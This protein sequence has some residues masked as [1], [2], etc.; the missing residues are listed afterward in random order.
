MLLFALCSEPYD[1]SRG[2]TKPCLPV[3][4]PYIADHWVVHTS[5]VEFGIQ[6]LGPR[7]HRD[8]HRPVSTIV[9]PVTAWCLEPF[10]HSGNIRRMIEKYLCSEMVRVFF[11][12]EGSTSNYLKHVEEFPS[13]LR[14]N[15]SD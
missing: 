1:S 2:K 9:P 4:F 5:Q 15:K 11:W 13:W 10:R 8:V 3:L 12:G 6:F 14:G 7:F